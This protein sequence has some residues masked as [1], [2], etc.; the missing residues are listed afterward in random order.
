MDK[1]TFRWDHKTKY[2]EELKREH[3]LKAKIDAF[4]YYC[5]SIYTV[6]NKVK[7]QKTKWKEI[8][9]TPLMMNRYSECINREII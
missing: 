6:M 9:V 5:Y 2:N 3:T 8:F 1:S 4:D 7:N